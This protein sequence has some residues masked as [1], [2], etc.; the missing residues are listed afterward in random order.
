MG[1]DDVAPFVNAVHKG[2][3]LT[4][5]VDIQTQDWGLKEFSR[6]LLQCRLAANLTQEELADRSGIGRSYISRLESGK[7]MAGR[8]RII[9]PPIETVD[10]LARELAPIGKSEEYINRARRLCGYPAISSLS[11][12]IPGSQEE[13]MQ[14]VWWML[15]EAQ[16]ES[17]I[18]IAE[19]M[20]RVQDAP[21]ESD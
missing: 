20:A 13:R 4:N 14:R 12:P 10:S 8:W 17:L 16:R 3:P 5:M 7:P 6:W 19:G 9:K 2:D 15:S 1:I 11:D 18:G 21:T